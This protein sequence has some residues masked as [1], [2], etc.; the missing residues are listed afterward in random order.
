MLNPYQTIARLTACLIASFGLGTV[1]NYKVYD[2]YWNGTINRVQTVDFNIL[3]HTLPTTLSHLLIEGKNLEIQNILD[4][5]YGL[6]GLAIT[7]SDVTEVLYHTSDRE[8]Y[9]WSEQLS[10][11]S[12]LLNSSS[13]FSNLRDPIPTNPDWTYPHAYALEIDNGKLTNSGEIIGKLY[14]VRSRPPTFNKE[15]LKFIQSFWR[16]SSRYQTYRATYISFLLSGLL[17]FIFIEAIISKQKKITIVKQELQSK[18]DEYKAIKENYTKRINLIKKDNLKSENIIQGL[19]EEINSIT[20][21]NT[22]LISKIKDNQDKNIDL[23]EEI[24]FLYE[25]NQKI[26]QQKELEIQ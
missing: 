13:L 7:N 4:S 17:F 23:K 8:S 6:F 9:S 11:P 5:N 3:S 14:F 16:D 18:E 24:D 12:N 20:S 15:I 19:K 25:E 26:I 21:K 1:F 10:N 22:D 2:S